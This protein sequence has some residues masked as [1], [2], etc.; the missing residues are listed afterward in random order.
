[1]HIALYLKRI[2]NMKMMALLYSIA[3]H[4]G[5]VTMIICQEN[6]AFKHICLV[7]FFKIC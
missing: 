6:R 5:A 4:I 3:Q 2:K 1:M 7:D